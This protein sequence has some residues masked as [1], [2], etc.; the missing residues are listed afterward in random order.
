M[1]NCNYLR[2]SGID[3]RGQLQKIQKS[4]NKLQP[5]FEALT[6]S[7]EAIKL[8]TL[9]NKGVITINLNFE[10]GLFSSET[11]EYQFP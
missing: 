11:K 5:L 9:Q 6:N 7:M 2:A 4:A 8:K 10:S 3:F 1:M